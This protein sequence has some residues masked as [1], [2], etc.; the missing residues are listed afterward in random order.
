MSGSI[1]INSRMCKNARGLLKWN[2][3]DLAIR[4]K[5]QVQRLQDFEQGQFQLM[6]SENEQVHKAFTH[7]GIEFGN[8]GDITFARVHKSSSGNEGDHHHEEDKTQK[9]I[10]AS[11]DIKMP[12]PAHPISQEELI[13]LEWLRMYGHLPAPTYFYP[14]PHIPHKK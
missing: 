9:E 13:R 1:R 4:S 2:V 6:K 11:L 10:I 3:R 7:A 12:P 14:Y 5:L 8:Q